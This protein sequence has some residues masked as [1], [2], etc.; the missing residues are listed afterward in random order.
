MYVGLS[1]LAVSNCG[2]QLFTPKPI[3][4]RDHSRHQKSNRCYY[5]EYKD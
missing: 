4:N 5:I 1:T 3:E 2:G